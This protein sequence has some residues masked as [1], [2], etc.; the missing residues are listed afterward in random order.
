MPC[1]GKTAAYAER[2]RPS[3]RRQSNALKHCAG[4]C[5]LLSSGPIGWRLAMQWR[6]MC[7]LEIRPVARVSTASDVPKKS[8]SIHSCIVHAGMR[9]DALGHAADAPQVTTAVS[10]APILCRRSAIRGPARSRAR[11]HGAAIASER[12]GSLKRAVNSGNC[13]LTSGF[14][15]ARHYLAQASAAQR[16]PSI[17][18]LGI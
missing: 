10:P 1:L 8:L 3:D 6:A 7:L 12:C 9:C 11:T 13:V 5:A 18:L 14:T 16:R 2:I 4:L 15:L 17:R